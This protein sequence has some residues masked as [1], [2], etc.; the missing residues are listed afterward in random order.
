MPTDGPRLFLHKWAG[1]DVFTLPRGVDRVGII[2]ANTPF[3]CYFF[4]KFAIKSSLDDF[5]A[6]ATCG[7]AV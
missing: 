1:P 3:F 2:F 7:S 5:L 4:E 6:D